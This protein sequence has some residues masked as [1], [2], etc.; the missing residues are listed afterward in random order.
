[1]TASWPDQRV[2]ARRRSAGL[3]DPV[4]AGR[5][6]VGRGAAGGRRR[7]AHPATATRARWR[8]WPRRA[9]RRP[10]PGARGRRASGGGALA[11][12]A[13]GSTTTPGARP[14][15]PARRP[16]RREVGVGAGTERPGSVLV[17]GTG[18][19]RRPDRRG[20]TCDGQRRRPAGLGPGRG[21]RLGREA[22]PAE[23]RLG[24]G[25]AL[26]WCARRGCSDP[27]ELVA[28][29]RPRSQA[30]A[31]AGALPSL[32]PDRG[33]DAGVAAAVADRPRRDA[34]W[35]PLFGRR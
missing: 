5:S 30:Y 7:A 25:A 18:A 12:S 10:R 22:V 1:M 35:P 11:T 20:W 21:A 27:P 26:R 3:P 29:A 8:W 34:S 23:A 32:A 17:A 15:S 4:T 14:A 6:P 9:G 28:V 31:V 13:G 33:P 19:R 2:C 16:V 24:D